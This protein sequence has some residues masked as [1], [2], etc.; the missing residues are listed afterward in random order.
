ME[1]NPYHNNHNNNINM[2]VTSDPFSSLPV[3][4]NTATATTTT[5]TAGGDDV[6]Q[7]TSLGFMEL[8]GFQDL[9]YYS[10]FDNTTAFH[11]QL[12]PP[13]S[14]HYLNHPDI[15]IGNDNDDIL[16]KAEE[17]ENN[18]NII[19]A[20]IDEEIESSSVVLNGQPP[21][22]PNSSSICTSPNAHQLCVKEKKI[23]MDGDATKVKKKKKEKAPRF[24]FMT[25]T[26]VDHLDDGYRWRKYGQKA[27]K[28]SR[29]PRSYFRCTSATCNVK[30]RVERCTDDPS[31][32]IT[33]YEGQHTHPPT[34]CSTPLIPTFNHVINTAA[35]AAATTPPAMLKLDQ[36]GLLQDMLP[37]HQ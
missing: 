6:E 27:V 15:I 16:H 20:T 26:D 35:F 7:K 11:H 33:T 28:N 37:C 4:T 29:F 32:V 2:N 30:K 22:S 17:A 31:Y 3:I 25:R 34:V 18:N 13:P 1:A 24:A 19:T 23:A 9:Y 12:P 5:N 10:M 14:P 21:S 8:L 36:G